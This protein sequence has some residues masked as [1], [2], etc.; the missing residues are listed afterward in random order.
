MQLYSLAAVLSVVWQYRRCEG[1]CT[2][3][4]WRHWSLSIYGRVTLPSW[5]AWTLR[6][7]FLPLS[8]RWEWGRCLWP[9]Y[10]LPW[11]VSA[12]ACDD[13]NEHQC[14][15][16]YP[17]TGNSH[18]RSPLVPLDRRHIS[19]NAVT[20]TWSVLHADT[21]LSSKSVSFERGVFVEYASTSIVEW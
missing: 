1:R 10:K 18:V 15:Y 11:C 13:A 5:G 17:W 16:C 8:T 2:V 20:T 14:G 12:W 4:W 7:F 21:Y 19:Q 3:A 6:S 9:Y